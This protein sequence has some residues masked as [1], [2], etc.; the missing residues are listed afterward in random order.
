MNT[1]KLEVCGM[2]R[3]RYHNPIAVVSVAVKWG[4]CHRAI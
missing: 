1:H 3:R 4:T 2:K